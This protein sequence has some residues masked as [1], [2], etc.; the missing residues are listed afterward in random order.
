MNRCEARRST[1]VHPCFILQK[2]KCSVVILS[3]QNKSKHFVLS[4]CLTLICMTKNFIFVT[5][6]H[7][8]SHKGTFFEIEI[9]T[10]AES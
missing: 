9:Y 4:N 8:T 5:L 3:V 2:H 7:K 1:N 6:D 10:S